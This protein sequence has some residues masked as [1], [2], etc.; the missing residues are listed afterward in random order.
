MLRPLLF[1]LFLLF[2]LIQVYDR[3]ELTPLIVGSYR[4]L[5]HIALQ[6][7]LELLFVSVFYPADVAVLKVID[8]VI[9]ESQILCM[10]L[11]RVGGEL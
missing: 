6:G 3:D 4:E 10:G 5:V 8:L 1:D 11:G 7:D 2:A 9:G